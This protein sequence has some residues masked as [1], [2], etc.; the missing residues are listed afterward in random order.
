MKKVIK[1]KRHIK[2]DGSVV[3]SYTRTID[4]NETK[5]LSFSI[6]QKKLDKERASVL[7]LFRG[8]N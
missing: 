3:E 7:D 6:K 4:T 2:S 5:T 1:V 8:E